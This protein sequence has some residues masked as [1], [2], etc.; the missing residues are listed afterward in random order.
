MASTAKTDDFWSKAEYTRKIDN[1]NVA[2][3]K[4]FQPT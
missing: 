2:K 1:I 4:D 3:K